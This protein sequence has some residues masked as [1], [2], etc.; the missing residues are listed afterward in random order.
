MKQEVEYEPFPFLFEEVGTAFTAVGRCK[1]FL[2]KAIAK[3]KK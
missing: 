3:T 1:L 2:K